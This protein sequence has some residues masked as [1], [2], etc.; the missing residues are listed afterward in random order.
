METTHRRFT[1]L[2]IIALL[3]VFPAF[4]FILISVLKYGLGIHGPFDA[5]KPMLES[6]GINESPGWNINLLILFGPLVAMILTLLQVLGI[7]WH[8][9]GEQ[10]RLHISIRKRWFPIVIAL[11]S[12]LVLATLFIYLFWENLN[13]Y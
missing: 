2:N 5:S 6:M 1:G 4:Y 10:F 13:H 3:L 7:E 9:A 8:F 12:G 11:L